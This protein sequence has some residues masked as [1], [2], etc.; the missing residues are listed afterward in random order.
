MSRVLAFIVLLAGELF[1]RNGT[2]G[3]SW[4]GDSCGLLQ[5]LQKE[6]IL[7][8]IQICVILARTRKFLKIYT[9]VL[10]ILKITVFRFSEVAKKISKLVNFQKK[11]PLFN[12]TWR[13]QIS[14]H[15]LKIFSK[16]ES[17]KESL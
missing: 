7:G 14:A 2:M 13:R 6:S 10:R 3:A 4:G 8:K 1:L 11:E 12:I 16:F 15:T 9:L 5:C 17:H